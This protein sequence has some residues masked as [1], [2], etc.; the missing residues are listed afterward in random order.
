MKTLLCLASMAVLLLAAPADTDITGKWS[1]TMVTSPDGGDAGP[2]LLVLK[3]SGSDITGTA[4]PNEGEQYS[5]TKGTRTGDKIT[6]EVQP[7]EGKSIKLELAL[8][9][10][11]LK[12]KITMSHDGESRTATIDVTRAK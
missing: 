8:A 12:G 4:G 7:N 11:H 1:G 2:A 3:Q 9:D 5:I 6:L 10:E